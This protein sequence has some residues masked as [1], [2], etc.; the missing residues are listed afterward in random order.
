VAA[1]ASSDALD[2]TQQIPLDLFQMDQIDAKGLLVA[3]AFGLGFR[4]H[5]AIV[6]AARELPEMLGCVAEVLAQPVDA[7]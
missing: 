7:L 4:D 3:D 5:R 1:Q 6:N 2:K